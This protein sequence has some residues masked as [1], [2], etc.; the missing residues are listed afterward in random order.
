[1]S[2]HLQFFLASQVYKILINSVTI[3]ITPVNMTYN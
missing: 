3:I 1:M 2:Q